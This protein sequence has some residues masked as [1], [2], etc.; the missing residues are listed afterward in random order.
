MMTVLLSLLSPSLTAVLLFLSF[1]NHNL[2]WLVWIAF[3]PLLLGIRQK[4]PL[5]A[6]LLCWF[7]GVIFYLG[8]TPWWIKEFRSV[9]L[10]A[11]G[12]GYIYL[13]SYF[14]AFGFIISLGLRK[15]KLP[16]LA[17]GVVWVALEYLRSNL[18]FLAFP[19]GNA[20]AQPIP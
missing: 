17:A 8:I 20:W 9:S 6:F 11:S 10:V 7:C 14:A 5:Q 3:V 12:L 13:S 1:P 15:M 19:W 2:P 18:S 16:L 4:R